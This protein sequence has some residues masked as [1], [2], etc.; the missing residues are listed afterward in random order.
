MGNLSSLT[1]GDT[2]F[3][4]LAGGGGGGSDM[5]EGEYTI[6][7]IY[8]S[9]TSGQKPTSGA[10]VVGTNA[11]VWYQK[12]GKYL[13]AV[14]VFTVAN[15]GSSVS[16]YST[17]GFNRSDLFGDGKLFPENSELVFTK[18]SGGSISGSNLNTGTSFNVEP[19]L[20]LK[21]T[22]L[23]G[24]DGYTDLFVAGTGKLSGFPTSYVGHKN[25]MIIE[26]V[27]F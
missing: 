22:V 3:P 13:R 18:F 1:M 15:I 21:E 14:I 8:F 25:F 7:E 4:V 23:A 26:A 2:T 27:C 24:E 6:P 20:W 9:G 12:T 10:T 16:T 5:I 11:R 17:I 19:V